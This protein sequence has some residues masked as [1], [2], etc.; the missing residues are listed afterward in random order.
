LHLC[1]G[2]WADVQLFE[3][4][5]ADPSFL[6]QLLAALVTDAMAAAHADA[7]DVQQPDEL[8]AA[9]RTLLGRV[10][11]VTAYHATH[12]Q[13]SHLTLYLTVNHSSNTPS[14]TRYCCSQ[15]TSSL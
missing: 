1:G 7:C 10:V 4:E 8:L 15:F 2:W 6:R 13:I 12:A 14:V 3:A 9:P 5:R 11:M